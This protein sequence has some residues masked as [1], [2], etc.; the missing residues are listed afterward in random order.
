MLRLTAF[1]DYEYNYDDDYYYYYLA[2]E[3]NTVGTKH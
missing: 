3:H 2:R 1:Y